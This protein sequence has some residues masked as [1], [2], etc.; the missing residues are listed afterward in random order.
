MLKPIPRFATVM[1]TALTN[2]VVAQTDTTRT[3]PAGAAAPLYEIIR[4]F[5]ERGYRVTDRYRQ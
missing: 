4:G 3:P 2:T 1:L 5:E